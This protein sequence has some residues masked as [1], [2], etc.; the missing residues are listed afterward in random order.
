MDSEKSSKGLGDI[1]AAEYARKVLGVKDDDLEIA[2]RKEVEALFAK[3]CN[4]L[5][6]LSNFHFTPKVLFINMHIHTRTRTNR[7]REGERQRESVCVW[8]SCCT[9]LPT[10]AQRCW[11]SPHSLSL[12]LSHSH[13]HTHT[14]M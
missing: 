11:Q 14:H 8:P 13:T 9:A 1:Y 2:K 7:E 10:Q 4:R 5:D 12:S 6:M 3:V